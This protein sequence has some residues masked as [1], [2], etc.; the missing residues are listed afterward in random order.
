MATDAQIKANRRNAAKSTGPKTEKGKAKA[1]LNALKHGGRATTINVMP[2]LPHED[3]RELE[4]RIQSWIDDWQPRDATEDELVRRGAKLSWLL[5]RGERV[6]AA[7]LAHRV[8][9]PGERPGR[10]APTRRMKQVNDLGRK[11]FYDYQPETRL[12]ARAALGRRAGRVRRRAR[13]DRR[14]L[15]V[16]A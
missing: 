15:P 4:E 16:A 1:R 3:P 5:E 13:G 2:V 9:R 12:L 11:L 7:H 6:E 14:G 8:R 10:G